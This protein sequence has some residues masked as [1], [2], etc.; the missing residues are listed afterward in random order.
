MPLIHESNLICASLSQS[1]P[2]ASNFIPQELRN[3]SP[4]NSA[5]A[6]E[7]RLCNMK[8]LVAFLPCAR[9]FICPSVALYESHNACSVHW[10]RCFSRLACFASTE[11]ANYLS[12]REQL[13]EAVRLALGG[14]VAAPCYMPPVDGYVDA[15]NAPD[16]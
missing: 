4:S 7:A 16:L 3:D 13:P 15:V 14:D 6:P 9:Y 2:P 10:G 1:P 5:L 8:N 11:P 12:A